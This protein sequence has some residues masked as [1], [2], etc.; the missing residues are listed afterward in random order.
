MLPQ[1]QS[2]AYIKEGQVEKQKPDEVP[3]SKVL[4]ALML[5]VCLFI[6]L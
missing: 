6:G 4:I 2:E 1:G 3:T 5:N